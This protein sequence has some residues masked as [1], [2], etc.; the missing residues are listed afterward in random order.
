MGHPM[1][2]A[3]EVGRP[4]PTPSHRCHDRWGSK[5][6][7]SVSCP[8]FTDGLSRPNVASTATNRSGQRRT[9]GLL[10]QEMPLELIETTLTVGGGPLTAPLSANLKAKYIEIW[11]QVV[12]SSKAQEIISF[13]QLSDKIV[14]VLVVDSGGDSLHMAASA[15]AGGTAAKYTGGIAVVNITSPMTIGGTVIP[16][17]V[18]F[19]H[20]IGHAKQNIENAVWYTDLYEKILRNNTIS[21]KGTGGKLKDLYI[22][23]DPAVQAY[24]GAFPGL[25]ALKNAAG[26]VWETEYGK[27][28]RRKLEN[29][30]LARHEK[31]V[32]I[33]MQLPFRDDYYA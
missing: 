26:S 2:V 23:N 31:P 14:G 10:E 28:P 29:D 25:R 15:M 19:L 8:A 9:M 22:A 27:E 18:T 11:G 3:C 24:K 32:L 5:A 30:N 17:G 7:L 6:A 1:V 4:T 16:L 21:G 13:L 12:N 20:E 33:E